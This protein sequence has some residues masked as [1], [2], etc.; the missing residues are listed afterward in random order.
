[1]IIYKGERLNEIIKDKKSEIMSSTGSDKIYER[2]F[3]NDIRE[4]YFN[5]KPKYILIVNG[6]QGTGKTFGILQAVE[7][8]DN[9]LYVCAQENDGTTADDYIEL[10]KNSEEDYI[11]IDNYS[12]INDR[13]DLDCCLW[14]LVKSGKHLVITGTNSISFDCPESNPLIH[15]SNRVDINI[16]TYEEF[17]RI[18]Q[19]E[20][21][22]RQL[23]GISE[24][25][26]SI[27]KI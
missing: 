27:Q 7:D 23:F 26:R 10:L 17:C 5:S 24:N 16:F 11:I 25:R 9:V 19:K 18:Y 20:Y 4:V 1:M 3:V 13:Y 6:L 12:F 22:K 8:L 21:S 14:T 15:N 2:D